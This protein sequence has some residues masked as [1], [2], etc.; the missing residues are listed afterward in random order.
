MTIQRLLP[1]ACFRPPSTL[2]AAARR[3]FAIKSP[4]PPPFPT[5]PTCPAP[6]CPCEEAPKLP[7]G[8]TIDRVAPLNGVIPTYAQQ[9]LVCTGHFTWP[10]KIE[11]GNSGDNLA[12]DLKELVGAQGKY[13]DPFHNVMIL[14]ASFPSTPA[15]TRRPDLQ[16]DSVYVLPLFKYVPFLPRISF[17]HVEALV[18]AYL[19]PDA[20]HPMY[21]TLSPVH[22]D[23]LLRKP[24]YE[25][26]LWGARDVEDVMVLI[27]GHGNRD[28]RCGIYGPVLRR[29]FL[30]KLPGKGVEVLKGPVEVDE[31]DV[32][33]P[34]LDR[35][36]ETGDGG[37]PTARVALVSHV[38]GHKFAGNVILYMPPSMKLP[39]GEPHPLAGHGIWYGRVEPSHVEGIIEETILGGKVIEEL[40]RGGIKRDGQGGEMLRI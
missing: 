21:D 34:A 5:T 7:D 39:N 10:S 12:A 26:I 4:F 32:D 40:F 28:A 22:R 17:E 16:T 25:S 2:A 6:T 1:R 11:Q 23:R 20:L 14:N 33:K 29:E 8:F 35:P 15:P 31:D 19:Q 27:C 36:A 37:K 38:G 9:V 3:G 24:V 30:D 18:R 13:C